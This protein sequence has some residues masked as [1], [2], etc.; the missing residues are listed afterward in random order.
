MIPTEA[1]QCHFPVTRLH[2][3][4]SH[5]L[6][7]ITFVI[8]ENTNHILKN[9][10]GKSLNITPSPYSTHSDTISCSCDLFV[11]QR[12]GEKSKVLLI[13]RFTFQEENIYLFG[14]NDGIGYL[15]RSASTKAGR[16]QALIAKQTFVCVCERQRQ[17]DHDL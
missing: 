7:E 10:F 17:R 16:I 2:S 6:D 5:S 8:M 3:T 12:Y 4:F 13:L 14:Q 9:A 1:S 11:F 15:C